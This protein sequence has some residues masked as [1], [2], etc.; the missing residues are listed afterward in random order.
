MDEQVRNR[1]MP[2][3][4]GAGAAAEPP[5]LTLDSFPRAIVHFDGDA[6]FAA[7]EQAVDPSLKG[8]P[9][10]TGKER[11]II[12]CASYEAKAL[13]IRRGIGLWEARRKCPSLVVLPSD[14]ETYSLYS[15]R[16]FNI[17]RRFTPAVEEHSIDEGFADLTGL[18]RLHRCSYEEIARR[19][20]QAV[21]D[22]LGI[23]VSV[24]LSLSKSLAKLA[25]KFRKPAGFT[26]VAGHHI[27]IF[28]RRRR[29]GD[30]WGFGPNTVGLLEKQGLRTPYDFVTKPE[31]WAGR[32]L[33]KIG[34][35]I[36]NELRG[37]AVYP[38]DAEAK[39]PQASVSKC[40][41]FTAPSSDR[42]Y[43]YAKLV[44]NVESAFIKLRR[45]R[46]R[47]RT[48]AVALRRQDFAHRAVGGA[49]NRPTS[50]T[51]EVLPVV[52]ELF[53]AIYAAGVEYRGTMVL[54][55]DLEA[56][57][58]DQLD[59]FEDRLRLDRMVRLSRAIDDL[60][61][62]YGKHCVSF[63]PSLF[64]PNHAMTARDEQPR[65]KTDLLPGETA[66]RRLAIPKLAI[67]V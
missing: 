65:R 61:R 18:R 33:G 27:H 20:Q 48:I 38:V 60:G 7:V 13:G 45:H 55:E 50:A 43:V 28:L 39:A 66:R 3:P 5:P 24:G 6:F 57:G 46:L 42:D 10:V 16:M 22:D 56:D 15:K 40:K 26:A 2:A 62:T 54:L 58:S 32:L 14:Y 4:R 35:E 25:S 64:L 67:S 29:L 37:M 19:I 36:W 1:P 34:R 31:A 30:V 47:A 41:T 63:G 44:R 52:R 59:L 21:R 53:D 23:T 12:A 49:L 17:V 9:L 11:G 51:P 8:R